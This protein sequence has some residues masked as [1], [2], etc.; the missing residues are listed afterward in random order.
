M[1]GVARQNDDVVYLPATATAIQGFPQYDD[2]IRCQWVD[3]RQD[4]C[5][6]VCRTRRGIQEH[7]R[8]IHQWVND[9]KRGGDVRKKNRQSSNQMWEEHVSCQRFF[10]IQSVNPIFPSG[11]NKMKD[12]RSKNPAAL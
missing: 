1:E 3:E 4:Q 6:Y 8:E 12:Q 11:Q 9:R 5:E 10:S 7:C 2:G